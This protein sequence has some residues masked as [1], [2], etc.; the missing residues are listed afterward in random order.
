[1]RNLILV[2][3]AASIAFALSGCGGSSN[4]AATRSAKGSLSFTVKWPKKTRL[5][6]YDSTYIFVKLT[7][8]SGTNLGTQSLNKTEGQTT[9][10]VT[11]N[12]IDPGAVTLTAS[13]YP[14]SAPGDVAQATGSAPSTIVAGQTANVTVT[15]DDTIV[16]LVITPANPTVNPGYPVQLTMTAYDAASDVVLVSPNTVTWASET[17]GTMAVSSNGLVT[18][19]GVPGSATIQVTET[20]SGKT[21]TTVATDPGSPNRPY[22]VFGDVNS[23]YVYCATFPTIQGMQGQIDEYSVGAGGGLTPLSTPSFVLPAGYSFTGQIRGRS[24]FID[25]AGS[26]IFVGLEHSGGSNW[27]MTLT[28]GPNGVLAASAPYSIQYD[29]IDFVGDSAGK[30][31]YFA[32]LQGFAEYAINSDGSLTEG[33]TVTNGSIGGT[34]GSGW[35]P[36]TQYGFIGEFEVMRNSNGTLTNLGELGPGDDS[37]ALTP[38]DKYVYVNFGS[39]IEVDTL[40]LGTGQYNITAESIAYQ[41]TGTSGY[42]NDI[43]LS[44][45]GKYLFARDTKYDNLVHAFEINSDGT[46]TPE[47]N[48]TVPAVTATV[49]YPTITYSTPDVKYF[50]NP[51][52]SNGTI[53]QFSIG[54]NGGLT[55]LSPATVAAP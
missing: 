15:M 32:F 4:G 52:S 20:E 37:M 24:I 13:A 29:P 51:D 7:N 55:A 2:L 31:L 10:T 26:Y 43:D 44:A 40:T 14:D 50:Y 35:I 18:S 45:D 46:L 16:R 34:T 49:Y 21:A 47:T 11:F 53:S 36:G 28:V 27:M 54:S 17:P 9:A 42:S 41:E 8:A 6:P 39:Y 5:I 25:P 3:F 38:N 23:K 48:G 1:M 12:N 19:Q 30:N 22:Y 33:Q